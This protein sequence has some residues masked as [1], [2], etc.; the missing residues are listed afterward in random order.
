MCKKIC[1]GQISWWWAGPDVQAG[2][3]PGQLTK[4]NN[5]ITVFWF[6]RVYRQLN[7]TQMNL[8]PFLWNF[9]SNKLCL[10]LFVNKFSLY[11]IKKLIP[12]LSSSVMWYRSYNPPLQNTRYDRREKPTALSPVTVNIS[13]CFSFSQCWKCSLVFRL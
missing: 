11:N 13:W 1:Y 12:L 5:G 3:E 7:W 10:T 2:R 8:S 6:R 9:C 4:S